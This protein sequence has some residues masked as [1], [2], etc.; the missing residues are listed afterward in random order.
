MPSIYWR[1]GIDR[2][3]YELRWVIYILTIQGGP[4]TKT[5]I[6]NYCLATFD[7]CP[8]FCGYVIKRAEREGIIIFNCSKSSYVLLPM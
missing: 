5:R 8:D 4:V 6:K 7:L 3:F 1:I 2:Y